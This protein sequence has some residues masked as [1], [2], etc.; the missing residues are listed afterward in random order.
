MFE[1]CHKKVEAITGKSGEPMATPFNCSK[2]CPSYK[3][4]EKVKTKSKIL[5][6]STEKRGFRS[7]KVSPRGTCVNKEITSKLTIKLEVETTTSCKL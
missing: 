6:T 1:V 3:T 7:Y 4:Y 5:I 2:N